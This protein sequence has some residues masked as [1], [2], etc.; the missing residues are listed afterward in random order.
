MAHMPPRAEAYCTY[1]LPWS[2]TRCYNRAKV[3]DFLE[4][5]VFLV[6]VL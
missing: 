6:I 2:C 4:G 5:D 3:V 1:T